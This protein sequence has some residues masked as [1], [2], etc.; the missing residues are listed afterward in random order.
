[1]P[2]V[3]TKKYRATCLLVF[4]I[5]PLVSSNDYI[6]YSSNQKLDLHYGLR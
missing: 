4:M 6:D 1:M 3:D 2:K 5:K